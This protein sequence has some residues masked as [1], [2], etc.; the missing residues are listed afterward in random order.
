MKPHLWAP[1]LVF[2]GVA[3]PAVLLLNALGV[4]DTL[5]LIIAIVAGAAATAAVQKN[6]KKKDG[7]EQ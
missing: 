7:D 4:G 1:P 5:R 6:L 2:L 3:I